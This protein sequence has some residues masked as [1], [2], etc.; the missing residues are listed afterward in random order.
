MGDMKV[1]AQAM[2]KAAPE[3]VAAAAKVA[4]E[5]HEVAKEHIDNIKKCALGGAVVGMI[6][7]GPGG[8]VA[9]TFVGGAVGSL[10]LPA[11]FVTKQAIKGLKKLGDFIKKHPEALLATPIVA[12][13][14]GSIAAASA[15][16][17][18]AV[19]KAKGNE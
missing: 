14:A 8:A 18:A 5:A 7:G 17:A 11:E 15:G 12:P 13:G 3:V 16:A 1:P 6:A 19:A 4:K 9:G 10:I 2:I